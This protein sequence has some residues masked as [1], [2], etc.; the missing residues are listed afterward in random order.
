MDLLNFVM[1]MRYRPNHIRIVY[2]DKSAKMTLKKK[3]RTRLPGTELVV[4]SGY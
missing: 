3:L 1:R 4:A 2:A